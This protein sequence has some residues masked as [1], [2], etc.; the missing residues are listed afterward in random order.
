MKA[1]GMGEPRMKSRMKGRAGRRRRGQ[2]G[3]PGMP[4]L[5]DCCIL[6]CQQI[7][8]PKAE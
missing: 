8:P 3:T 5:P 4:V 1:V 2:E 6:P 7:S